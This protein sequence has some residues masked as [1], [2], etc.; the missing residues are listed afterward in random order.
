VRNKKVQ[1]TADSCSHVKGL[2]SKAQPAEG[3]DYLSKD[4]I[5]MGHET[6]LLAHS[7]EIFNL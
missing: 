7:P 1:L 2:T 6:A 3:W 4:T 5:K